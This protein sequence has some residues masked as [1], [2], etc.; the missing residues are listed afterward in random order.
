MNRVFAR[1]SNVYINQTKFSGYYSVFSL[2]ANLMYKHF[3]SSSLESINE[4]TAPSGPKPIEP[5]KDR[6]KGK[7]EIVRQNLN[8]YP[9][10]MY[11]GSREIHKRMAAVDC[12][13]EVHDARIPFSGRGTSGSETLRSLRQVRP[14]VL[15]LNKSDLAFPPDAFRDPTALRTMDRI[16]DILREV[17]GYSKVYFT[18]HL[19]SFGSR[20]GGERTMRPVVDEILSD[21]FELGDSYA[22]VSGKR[23]RQ[24]LSEYNLLVCGIPNVGKSSLIN[25]LRKHHMQ[26]APRGGGVAVGKLAGV[27]RAVGNR[28]LVSDRYGP[29]VYAFDTPGIL[30]PSAVDVQT[31]LRVALCGSVNVDALPSGMGET[32]VDYLLYELNRKRRF[33]Y[34]LHYVLGAPTDDVLKLLL[35]VCLNRRV[36]STGGSRDAHFGTDRFIPT[37]A[38]DA[39]RALPDVEGAARLV[40]HEFN[41]GRLGQL[42]LDEIPESAADY[43]RLWAPRERS[44]T[45]QSF[46]FVFTRS[47]VTF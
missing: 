27:T 41:E 19:S 13:I 3:S 44:R 10:H 29:R 32:L 7:R 17:D 35:L 2:S 37:S 31:A 1:Q 20:A 42:V 22:Q 36:V 8:W 33:E 6:P 14:H 15:V 23:Q 30:E 9:G 26:N 28:V 45:L 40:L 38:R 21:V 24:A 46:P 16:S 39:T 34:A 5:P 43:E 11:R 18:R 25:A 12:V 47:R 4:S